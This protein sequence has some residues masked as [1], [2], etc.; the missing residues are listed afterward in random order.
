M[1]KVFVMYASKDWSFYERLTAHA[2]SAKLVAEFDHLQSKQPWFAAWKAQ[3]RSRIYQCD[4]AIVL[5]SRNTIDGGIE[6][7]LECATDFGMPIL[8]VNVDAEQKGSVPKEPPGWEVIN[9]GDWPG[10][11]RFIQLVKRQSASPS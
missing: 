10:L 8:G 1:T 9:W 5:V 7:E 2:R 6:W 3:C 4:G 11:A